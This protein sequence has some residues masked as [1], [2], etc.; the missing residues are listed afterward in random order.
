MG[1]IFPVSAPAWALP[2]SPP[3]A[4]LHPI[5][6]G[7]K[8]SLGLG[9]ARGFWSFLARGRFSS[10]REV[11]FGPTGLSFHRVVQHSLKPVYHMCVFGCRTSFVQFSCLPLSQRKTARMK[12]TKPI[13]WNELL[14]CLF[15]P[16]KKTQI[17][18]DASGCGLRGQ[19][20]KMETKD[21]RHVQ[22]CRMPK[23]VRWV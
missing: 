19:N 11:S 4:R 12:Y 7:E 8:L 23:K 3:V 5:V 14:P 9:A 16:Q 22:Q 20:N 17:S 15:D 6:D 18:R 2:P 21:K 1:Y 10:G 13:Y